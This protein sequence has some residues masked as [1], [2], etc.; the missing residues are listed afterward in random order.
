MTQVNSFRIKL[1]LAVNSCFNAKFLPLAGSSKQQIKLL[2]FFHVTFSYGNPILRRNPTGF[3]INF[4]AEKWFCLLA[5]PVNIAVVLDSN[6]MVLGCVFIAWVQIKFSA[7]RKAPSFVIVA[8]LTRDNLRWPFPK[9][10]LFRASHGI[11]GGNVPFFAAVGATDRAFFENAIKID[12]IK[13]FEV[14]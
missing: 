2:L 11:A 10:L 14:V 3:T 4:A 9:L 1:K 7:T 12:F 13:S 8:L 6:S 5:L